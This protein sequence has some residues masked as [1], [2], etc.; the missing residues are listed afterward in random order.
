MDQR[1]ENGRRGSAIESKLIFTTR[2]VGLL[3]W[4]EFRHPVIM[5]IYNDETGSHWNYL[6]WTFHADEKKIVY[7][8]NL[9]SIKRKVGLF[10]N[11]SIIVAPL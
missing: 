7:T 2:A 11:S 4:S 9:F 8:T 1:E 10:F 5:C 3:S 6:C